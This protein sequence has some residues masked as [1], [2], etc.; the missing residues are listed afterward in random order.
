MTQFVQYIAGW[1][2]SPAEL[3]ENT[4]IQWVINIIA[5]IVLGFYIR[6]LVKQHKN[7]PPK[8]EKDKW[9]TI[10][11]GFLVILGGFIGFLVVSFMA[12]PHWCST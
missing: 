3:A 1:S 6:S 10:G 12:M 9:K 5:L 11:L 2:C 7:N 8:S 4:R